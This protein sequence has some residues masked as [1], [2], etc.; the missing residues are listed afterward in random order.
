MRRQ[1]KSIFLIALVWLVPLLL[2]GQ[3]DVYKSAEAFKYLFFDSDKQIE[4]NLTDLKITSQHKSNN[5][6]IRHIYL[7]QFYENIPITNGTASVHLNAEGEVIYL[8]D[9][10][11]RKVSN[12]TLSSRN[13]I[14]EDSGLR[15]ALKTFLQQKSTSSSSYSYKGEPEILNTQLVYENSQGNLI[16]CFHFQIAT[17]QKNYIIIIN[18]TNGETIRVHNLLVSCSSPLEACNINHFP[19]SCPHTSNDETDKISNHS[20]DNFASFSGQ[21][22]VFPLPVESPLYGS[23][24]LKTGTE[25]IDILS[26]PYGWHD[27]DGDASTIEFDYTRGNNIYAFYAPAGTSAEPDAVKITRL[28]ATGDYAFG[29][30]PKPDN[31]SLNFDYN[32]SLSSTNATDFLEDAVTNAFVTAN[33]CHDIFYKYGFDE[34]AGNFQKTNHNGQGIGDDEILVRVQEG[35]GLNQASYSPSVDGQSPSIRLSLWTTD[36]PN[37]IDSD[38]DNGI[39]IHEYAHGLTTRL[40]GGADNIDCLTS[41]EQ[42]GEGWSDFFSLMLTM[43]DHSGNSQI[44]ADLLGEGIR[45]IGAYVLN[46]N[47]NEEGIRPRYY[48]SEMDETAPYFNELTYGDINSLA[49]PHGVGFLWCTMLWDMTLGLMEEYGYQNDI[50]ASDD[51]AGNIRAM[52]IVTEAIKMTACEPDFVNMRDAVL[53]A[54]ETL[55]GATDKNIAWEAFARRG[56]G[57]SATSG[58]NASFDLPSLQI[59]KTVNTED[60]IAGEELTYSLTIRNNSEQT[61][62]DVVVSD[63]YSNKLTIETVSDGGNSSATTVNWPN[64]T[65]LAPNTE[66]TRSFTATIAAADGTVVLF[67]EPV[68]TALPVGFVSSGA[69]ITDSGKPNNGGSS[70]SFWHLNPLT[71]SESSLILNLN[72]DGTSNNHLSFWQFYN[73]EKTHDGGVIEILDGTDWLDLGSRMIKNNYNSFIFDVLNTPV[74]VPIPSSSISGRRSFT[75]YSETYKNTIIDLSDFSGARQ[76]RFRFVSDDANDD[77]AC[78]NNLCEGWYLD[79]FQLLDMRNILN[80]ACASASGGTTNCGNIGKVGTIYTSNVLPV[81]LLEFTAKPLKE[82]IQLNWAT[83]SEINNSGFYLQRKSEFE[84]EF[85]DLAFI[86]SSDKSEDISHYTLLDEEVS[87]NI[88]YFY[89]LKQLD[90]SGAHSMSQIRNAKITDNTFT[91][92]L[93]PNP[94]V[95]ELIIKTNQKTDSETSYEVFNSNGQKVLNGKTFFADDLI[96]DTSQFPSGS[97]LLHLKNNEKTQIFKIIKMR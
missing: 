46:D 55:Y 34:V 20:S 30:V 9:N 65:S 33:A 94:V 5:S 73:T 44:D 37:Q 2:F 84:S 72:L 60:A 21:Y 26:S 70:L 90:Y 75:G 16:P 43:Q 67:E 50:Y 53:S 79:D 39:I 58:G 47:A 38:F 54:A 41:A 89:R 57:F 45:G 88:T 81:E 12:S 49:Y 56:L 66:L 28:N 74:G 64:I 76:I 13:L 69:W 8:N 83:G 63:V 4:P 22:N 61:L 78:H 59:I 87:P 48:T 19:V 6:G 35:T 7:K 91:Y 92:S 17:P 25:L 11:I 1:E 96:I 29:N 31:S 18:A 3:N 40:I 80:E 27:T 71:A 93:F 23:R 10:L 42:G 62:S 51:S 97:F 14:S 68:E 36:A 85:Y 24:S 77:A 15:A 32:N 82:T 86:E 95:N 52:H